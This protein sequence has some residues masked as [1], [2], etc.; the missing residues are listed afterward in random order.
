MRITVA[1]WASTTSQSTATTSTISWSMAVVPLSSKRWGR[2]VNSLVCAAAKQPTAPVLGDVE[3]I[4]G[5]SQ[6]RGL[7]A[8][9]TH[10][11]TCPYVLFGG[12]A[13]PMLCVNAR[14][15]DQR[16][17]HF[18]GDGSLPTKG[19][20]WA[21]A[22]DRSAASTLHHTRWPPVVHDPNGRPRRR[23]LSYAFH[24][25]IEIPQSSRSSA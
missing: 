21:S 12:P 1:A 7:V 8:L 13:Q 16:L 10:R 25:A 22:A 11:A 2:S 19:G 24:D 15:W 5:G 4:A 20:S 23:G 6:L 9:S 17:A 18:F 3:E 14:S